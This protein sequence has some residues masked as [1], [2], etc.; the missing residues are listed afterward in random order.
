MHSL[1]SRASTETTEGEQVIGELSEISFPFILF[2]LFVDEA[3]VTCGVRL[4]V[5][6]FR[7]LDCSPLEEVD[8]PTVKK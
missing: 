2:G 3:N 6:V 8:D 1:L 4:P 7:R 5:R